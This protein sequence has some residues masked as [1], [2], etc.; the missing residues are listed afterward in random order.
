MTNAENAGI[1]CAYCQQIGLKCLAFSY[2]SDQKICH[3]Y[4]DSLPVKQHREN[5]I[6][7]NFIQ[8]IKETTNEPVRTNIKSKCQL[9]KKIVKNINRKN[10]I[11]FRK[12]IEMDYFYG[13]SDSSDFTGA[14]N[15]GACCDYCKGIGAHCL[16]FSFLIDQQICYIY[17][18]LLPEKQNRNNTISGVV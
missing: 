12:L 5:S 9:G 18:D 10:K 7:G 6:S 16:A 4:Y 13:Y 8:I 14:S 2:F 17:Y 15:V 1:C 3:V 11:N